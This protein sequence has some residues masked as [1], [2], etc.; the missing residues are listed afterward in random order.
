VGS[1]AL[2]VLL[3]GPEII[4]RGLSAAFQDHRCPSAFDLRGFIFQGCPV[5]TIGTQ[6]WRNPERG[7][8]TGKFPISAL[9]LIHG[10]LVRRLRRNAGSD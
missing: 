6:D 7:C 8:R 2:A 3:T 10:W 9:I 1:A 5:E 4:F